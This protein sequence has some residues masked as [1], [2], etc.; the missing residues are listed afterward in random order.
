MSKFLKSFSFLLLAILIAGAAVWVS[1]SLTPTTRKTPQITLTAT[2]NNSSTTSTTTTTSTTESTTSS[3]SE[4]APVV[5]TVQPQAIVPQA[6][7]IV[8][9][10]APETVIYYEIVTEQPVETTAAYT[11]APSENA[12]TG[13]ESAL[14]TTE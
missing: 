2:N 14:V 8:E 13:T 3:A 1:F 11:D 9:T 4:T 5:T 6:P 7:V 12:Y 10:A